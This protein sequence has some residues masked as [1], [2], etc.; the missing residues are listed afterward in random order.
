VS[1]GAGFGVPDAGQAVALARA[2]RNR[3]AP[4]SLSVT[5]NTAAAIPDDG[6]RVIVTG[7][8]VPPGLES[9][10][11]S[12]T[13]GLQLDD[14]TPAWAVVDAGQAL[15]PIAADLTGKAALIQRGQNYFV[16]K[17]THAANAHARLAILYNNSGDERLFV[18]GADFQFLPIPSVFLGQTAGEALRTYLQQTPDARAQVSLQAVRLPLLVTN[19]LLCEHVALRVQC[20]HPRRADVRITLVSPA[21]TR[22]VL[23]HYNADTASA[24]GDWTY[25]STHHFY[26]SSAGL[27]QAEISDEQPGQTGSVSSVILTLQGVPITD[28]DH[29]GLDDDWERAALHTLEYGPQEDNDGD[30]ANN[31]RE[32]MAGTDPLAVEVPFRVEVSALDPERVRLSWPA[33]PSYSYQVYAG[34]DVHLPLTLEATLA[35][36]F[37]ELEWLVYA[38]DF[39]QQFYRVKQVPAGPK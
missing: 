12:P 28:T 4:V 34:S 15:G 21:G 10:P 33:L 25:Y 6:L 8:G 2:W 22:S 17:V 31:M 9:I 5:N 32:Q 35:G 30:G 20:S 39:E 19:T 23:H 1:H 38:S 26:E 11:A 36:R 7:T 14:P 3:P 29:D 13:D 27:W 16:E 37:P 18:N 24:L